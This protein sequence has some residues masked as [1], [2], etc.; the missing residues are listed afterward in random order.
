MYQQ[1]DS[2]VLHNPTN[3]FKAMRKLQLFSKAPNTA[4]TV[5]APF[6]ISEHSKPINKKKKK[7]QS[8]IKVKKAQARN[9]E[10]KKEAAAEAS[11]EEGEEGMIVSEGENSPQ[12]SGGL[13]SDDDDDEFGG[14][15]PTE[16][17]LID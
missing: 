13:D 2:Q 5:T 6:G 17:K 15:N 10:N 9:L 8:K 7:L 16:K 11:L 12:L 1:Y 4:K 14:F 3:K